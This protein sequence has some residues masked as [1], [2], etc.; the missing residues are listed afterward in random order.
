MHLKQEVKHQWTKDEKQN[1]I[2]GK[3]NMEPW[4]RISEVLEERKFGTW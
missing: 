2:K 4:K 3:K 1:Q